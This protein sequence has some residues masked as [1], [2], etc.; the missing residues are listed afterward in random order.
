M[1]LEPKKHKHDKTGSDQL[2]EAVKLK[3]AN[4]R[5]M[6]GWN[7]WSAWKGRMGVNPEDEV[8]ETS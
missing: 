4:S 5:E 2:K 1:E 7:W 8:K 6:W 3:I